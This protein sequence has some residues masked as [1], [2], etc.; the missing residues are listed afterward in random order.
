MSESPSDFKI[1]SAVTDVQMIASGRGV[2]LLKFLRDTY[3]GQN[4]RKMKGK[5]RVERDTGWIGYAEIHWYEAHGVG[6]VRW[7]IKRQLER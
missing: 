3:G 4:W 2:H 5:A 7:K 6:K 1:L